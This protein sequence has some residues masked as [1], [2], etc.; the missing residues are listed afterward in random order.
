VSRLELNDRRDASPSN[1]H[2]LPQTRVSQIVGITFHKT[3]GRHADLVKG[4]AFRPI[5]ISLHPFRKKA[6]L[7][8][9]QDPPRWG[10]YTY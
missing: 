5:A 9:L 1:A 3:P 7:R 6:A 4:P 8:I 2:I 10:T